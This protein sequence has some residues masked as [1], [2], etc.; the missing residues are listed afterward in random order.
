MTPSLL[1]LLLAVLGLML[2]GGGAL[3]LR[4]MGA[5]PALARRLAGPREMKVGGLGEPDAPR[6]RAVRV[7]G[8]IRCRDPLHVEGGERLVAFHRDVE[9]R[10]AGRWRTIERL[11]ETRSFELWDH[12]GSLTIDPARAAEPLVAIPSVWR[13]DPAELGEPHASTIA[14]L[15]ERDGG[16]ATEARSVT[17]TINVTDQ[18]LVL[19]RPVIDAGTPVRLEPPDGGFVITNLALDDAMRL[20]G[21]S[22]R[23]GVAI[24]VI[25]VAV[26]VALVA[27]GTVGAI[28]MALLSG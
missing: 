23:R 5:R 17:R 21:G 7:R 28:G 2:A 19:A 10:L 13:G 15:V 26:G 12:D 27:V 8:R 3:A 16:T 24:A 1:F 11:R 18:L 14:R 25:G 22:H 4:A 9:V 6:G 20:L